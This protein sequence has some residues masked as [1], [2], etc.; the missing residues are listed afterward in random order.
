M[1]A[2]MKQ[3]ITI[4]HQLTKHLLHLLILLDSVHFSDINADIKFY[5]VHS[6]FC[7]VRRDHETFVQ[8]RNKTLSSAANMMEIEALLNKKI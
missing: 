1:T 2:I 4:K 5:C 6:R 3:L 7:K 8:T